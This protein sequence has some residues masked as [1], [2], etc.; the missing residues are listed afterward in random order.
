MEREKKSARARARAPEHSPL[1]HLQTRARRESTAASAP[2]LDPKNTTAAHPHPPTT[3]H[4]GHPHPHAGALE[5]WAAAGGVASAARAGRPALAPRSPSHQTFRPPT[6]HPPTH[7]P[8][9]P[10]SQARTTAEEGGVSGP[11]GKSGYSEASGGAPP[12]AAATALPT[13]APGT[14]AVGRAGS[15]PAGAG[16][17]ASSATRRAATEIRRTAR[18]M[19]SRAYTAVAIGG[20][21]LALLA[22]LAPVLA[23][24]VL[25]PS[26]SPAFSTAEQTLAGEALATV[27]EA[28][29][30]GVAPK[31]LPS[32]K[33]RD[34]EER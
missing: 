33:V 29:R 5:G 18:G 7:P 22:G 2:A 21:L 9:T 10:P 1:S 13:G 24:R 16:R 8:N 11:A 17:R 14:P 15:P 3:S 27:I 20:T 4:G 19:P 34:K 6:H 30:H 28:A 12:T 23:A 32:T 25:L 31:G 26:S